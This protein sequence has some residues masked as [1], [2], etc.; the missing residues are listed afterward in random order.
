MDYTEYFFAIG[1][2][3]FMCWSPGPNTLLCAAHGNQHGWKGTFPLEIGMCIGFFTMA[4]MVGFGIEI[5]SQYQF[6]IESVRYV[7][8]AY[9]LY[10]AYHI[11]N[12]KTNSLDSQK[13]ENHSEEHPPA[14]HTPAEN[15]SEEHPSAKHALAE[16]GS[17]EHPSAKHP[18]AQSLEGGLELSDQP[19]GPINGFL[20]QFVNPKG[21]IYFTILM[22]IYAPR[23]G[24]AFSVKIILALT[25]TLV[26]LG[27]VLFSSGA[28][29]LLS[30]VFST[31]ESAKKVNFFLALVLAF[32]AI[33][34]A[35]HDLLVSLL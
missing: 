6:L 27:S 35:F 15:G 26:G 18:S 11:A 32:V 28:G 2:M 14:K 19:L 8:A 13:D 25:T 16:N 22:G 5:V 1:F 10:L 24:S 3:F 12:T 29:V 20:L 33:D 9:M 31:P 30:K 21:V 23:I 17:E 7:G 4:I 34:I